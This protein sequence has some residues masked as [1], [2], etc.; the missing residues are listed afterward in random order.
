DT[1]ATASGLQ[2][3]ITRVA[4]EIHPRDTFVL[5]AAGHGTS[6]GGRFYLIPQDYDGG[7]NSTA[8]EERAIWEERLQEWGGNHKAK[9]AIILRDASH[10]SVRAP[11]IVGARVVVR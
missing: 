1:A 5:F 10:R 11:F 4:S 8:F 3:I 6:Y 2:Q 9:K 7:T